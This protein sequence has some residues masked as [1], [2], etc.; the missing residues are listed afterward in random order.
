MLLFIQN[1]SRIQS[2]FEGTSTV[3]NYGTMRARVTSEFP[4]PFLFLFPFPFP[5]PFPLVLTL[6]LPVFTNLPNNSSVVTKLVLD[7]L[8]GTQ[9]SHLPDLLI[10]TPLKVYHI[11]T[12][13]CYRSLNGKHSSNLVVSLYKQVQLALCCCCCAPPPFSVFPAICET[14]YFQLFAKQDISPPWC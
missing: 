3:S 12:E 8:I 7:R 10:Y 11:Y 1:G 2:N 4:F 14:G 9:F 6:P 5:F 13:Y